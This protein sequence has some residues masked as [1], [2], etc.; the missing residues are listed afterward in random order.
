[1]MDNDE[2]LELFYGKSGDFTLSKQYLQTTFGL[3]TDEVEA[4][5]GDLSLDPIAREYFMFV[6]KRKE[7]VN[8]EFFYKVSV[9]V[10]K[11]RPEREEE[12]LLLGRMLGYYEGLKRS[13]SLDTFVS[14]L[15]EVQDM[16]RADRKT[17]EHAVIWLL[18]WRYLFW[19]QSGKVP[20][21]KAWRFYHDQAR[22]THVTHYLSNE[23]VGTFPNRTIFNLPYSGGRFLNDSSY[24]G[25]IKGNYSS[26][27]EVIKQDEEELSRTGGTFDEIAD[28]MGYLIE[29]VDRGEDF[30]VGSCDH[31]LDELWRYSFEDECNMERYFEFIN[32]LHQRIRDN[33]HEGQ[34]RGTKSRV[35]YALLDSTEKGAFRGTTSNIYVVGGR[36]FPYWQEVIPQ[37]RCPFASCDFTWAKCDHLIFNNLTERLL[38]INRGTEHLARVHHLLEK[39][40]GYGISAAG[41]YYHFG[42][43]MLQI[44]SEGVN[45]KL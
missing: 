41:F 43:P 7:W 33:P 27:D 25:F 15:Q 28:L 31:F 19:D 38:L 12:F 29:Q 17:V 36:P 16:F 9:G 3:G 40:N 44:I 21:L 45:D 30:T 20:R 37:Q 2:D 6:K 35:Y 1:M 26:V 5:I 8:P 14:S 42:T 32:D 10:L 13:K 18:T 24:V 11:V 39:G 22:V 23:T 4:I 34:F